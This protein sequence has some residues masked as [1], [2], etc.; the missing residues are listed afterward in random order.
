MVI[1]FNMQS[2]ERERICPCIYLVVN[3]DALAIERLLA[4]LD[5]HRGQCLPDYVAEWQ[6]NVAQI[7][8]PM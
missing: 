5:L 3:C 4:S 7:L 6:E 2:A 8:D 1:N